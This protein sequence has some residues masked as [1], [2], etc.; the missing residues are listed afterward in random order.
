MAV[1]VVTGANIGMG[2]AGAKQLAAEPEVAKIVITARSQEKIEATS[3]ALIAETGKDASFFEAVLLDLGEYKSIESAIEAFPAFDR[4]LLNAGGLGTGKMHVSGNGMTDAMVINTIGN[5]ML[6]DG[7]ILAGKIKQGT[8]VCW[9]GSEVSRSVYSFEGLLPDYCG[10]FKEKDIEWA[11]TKDYD[12][13]CSCLPIRRQMGD[14]KNAK[15]VGHMHFINLAKEYPDMHIT[16]VS[17]GAVGGSFAGGAHCPVKQLM[18][19]CP[20]MFRCLCV[21]HAFRTSV[22][23]QIGAQRYV[24]AMTGEL[25][26]YPT[27]SVL[28]SPK[29]CGLC[30]WGAFG[31]MVDNRPFVP[32]YQDEELC[33]KASIKVREW[34][35]KWTQ[36]APGQMSMQDGLEAMKDVPEP[37]K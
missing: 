31:Q 9:V 29:T 4:I 30:M 10:N 28:L 23:T 1:V 35:T 13:P 17:P 25:P 34:A 18:A 15:I 24:D 20:C 37:V 8:R 16:S 11:I 21:T 26:K 12:G 5:A 3:S 2:F 14:Y 36:Q 22:A 7:L 19:F 33:K 27:G 32:Y 6:V